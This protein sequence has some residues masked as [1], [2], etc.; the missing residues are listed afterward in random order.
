M[1][2]IL[3]TPKTSVSPTAT[4]KSH[5]AYVRPST[6]IVTTAF[7]TTAPPSGLRAALR[8]REAGADPVLGLHVRRRVDA[9]GREALDVV[10]DDHLLRRVVARLADRGVLHR[11]VS[12]TERHADAAGGRLPLGVG[13]RGSDL[14]AGRLLTA[15]S[16]HRLLDRELQ[17]EQRL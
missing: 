8:A 4:M 10:E 13:E 11:L 6:R 9:V 17:P 3:R 12:V 14:L 7:T 2:R 15:V 16:D 5:D 1:L